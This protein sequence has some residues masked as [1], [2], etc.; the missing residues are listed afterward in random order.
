MYSLRPGIEGATAF[1]KCPRIQGA[2]PHA[3]LVS[4]CEFTARAA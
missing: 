1:L 3:L 4:S 2:G